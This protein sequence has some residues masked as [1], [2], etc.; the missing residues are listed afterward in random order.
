MF[1]VKI[2]HFTQSWSDS[3]IWDFYFKLNITKQYLSCQ[4]SI[5]RRLTYSNQ[6]FS[7][8]FKWKLSVNNAIIWPWCSCS[9]TV[10]NAE[11]IHRKFLRNNVWDRWQ[12]ADEQYGSLYGLPACRQPQFLTLA[13]VSD[14]IMQ[15]NSIN[16]L[17]F[18]SQK[19]S[20][21]WS[22][23]FEVNSMAHVEAVRHQRRPVMLICC[24]VSVS[25][26]LLCS[27]CNAHVQLCFLILELY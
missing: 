8:G 26:I 25:F 19:V 21:W 9:L 17:C 11:F 7:F 16:K 23:L 3:L 24:L 22:Q 12:T 4:Q 15:L 18:R 13:P 5:L 14:V 20:R 1:Q 6:D 2:R 27:D 10:Q